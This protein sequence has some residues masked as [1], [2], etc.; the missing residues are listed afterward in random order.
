MKK[1]TPSQPP[2]AFASNKQ[3]SDPREKPKARDSRGKAGR[4]EVRAQ[5]PRVPAPRQSLRP[6]EQSK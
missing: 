5:T 4:E 1:Q 6:R 3:P 2:K